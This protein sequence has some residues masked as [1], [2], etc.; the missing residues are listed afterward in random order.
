MHSKCRVYNLFNDALQAFLQE[1]AENCLVLS[2]TVRKWKF[3]G[4]ERMNSRNRREEE[5][6]E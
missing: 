5:Q 4:E 3:L 6:Q 1:M 2:N